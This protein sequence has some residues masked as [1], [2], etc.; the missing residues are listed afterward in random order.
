M[1]MQSLGER[2]SKVIWI[3]KLENFKALENVVSSYIHF[4]SKIYNLRF[5]EMIY[6]CED[7]QIISRL[8]YSS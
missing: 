4:L 6:L 7:G 1:L 2:I 5:P 3:V 8:N